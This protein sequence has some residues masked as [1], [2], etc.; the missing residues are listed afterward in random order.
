MRYKAYL[1]T[2]NSETGEYVKIRV[3]PATKKQTSFATVEAARKRLE[4][5]TR[6]NAFNSRGII[7][8]YTAEAKEVTTIAL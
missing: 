6:H 1:Q 8:E 5:I 2:K 7:C 4:Q 3:M